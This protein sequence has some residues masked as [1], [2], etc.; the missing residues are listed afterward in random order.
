VNE[1]NITNDIILLYD[2]DNPQAAAASDTGASSGA[3]A[4]PAQQ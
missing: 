2:Q 3:A 1:V 4:K